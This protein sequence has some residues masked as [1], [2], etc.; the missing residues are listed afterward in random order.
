MSTLILILLIV[1]AIC[2]AIES[3]WHRSLIAVG[4]L[5]RVL[6]ALIPRLT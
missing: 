5:G 2:F 1:A 6:A 3:V 4:L